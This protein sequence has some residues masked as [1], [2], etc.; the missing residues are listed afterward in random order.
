MRSGEGDTSGHTLNSQSEEGFF[1]IPKLVFFFLF[2]FLF[3]N[4]FKN[5]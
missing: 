4:P 2:Y 3:F 5:A 1:F